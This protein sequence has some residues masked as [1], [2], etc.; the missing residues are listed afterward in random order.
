MTELQ[1][2]SDCIVAEIFNNFF[3]FM[4]ADGRDLIKKLGE[5]PD[6]LAKAAEIRAVHHV[7]TYVHELAGLFHS[8]YNGCRILG[9]D[10]DV[11]QARIALVTAVKHVV[12]HA[13]KILGVS[14]PE[15][16]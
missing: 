5:Y 14:A 1:K 15:H 8:F 9:V 11:Q 12:E 3:Q 13:L 7:A 16:M 4:H 6:M 10:E 2:R